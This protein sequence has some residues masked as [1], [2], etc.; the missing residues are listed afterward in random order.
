MPRH[1]RGDTLPVAL[2]AQRAGGMPYDLSGCTAE[3]HVHTVA[4]CIG[5]A[6]TI[7]DATAGAL[8]FDPAPLDDLS[9]RAYRAS[10]RVT[11]RDGHTETLTGHVVTVTEGCRTRPAPPDIITTITA[12]TSISA[13]T[14]IE[15]AV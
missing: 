9:A 13:A 11:R 7:H 10:I 12:G 5:I 2:T 4:D 8:S 6:A 15:E 3:V 14:I 1:V